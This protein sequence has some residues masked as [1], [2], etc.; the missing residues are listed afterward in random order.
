MVKHGNEL[1][2]ETLV[3]L[4][5]VTFSV[6]GVNDR[7]LFKM[8]RGNDAEDDMKKGIDFYAL[9]RLLYTKLKESPDDPCLLHNKAVLYAYKHY[10]EESI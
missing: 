5:Q 8:L 2:I 3:I 6:V 10:N 1:H 4:N 9:R 7:L